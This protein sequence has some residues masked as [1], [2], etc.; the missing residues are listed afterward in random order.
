MPRKQK[1]KVYRTPIGFHDAYVAAPSQKAALEAWGSEHDLFARGVAERIDD[2]ALTREPLEKPGV[3]I[4][5]LRGTTAE[6]IAALPA[7]KHSG[8][9]GRAAQPSQVEEGQA[10]KVKPD[11]RPVSRPKPKPRPD[12]AALDRAEQALAAAKARHERELD[13]LR[14]REAELARERRQTEQAQDRERARLERALQKT[15]EAYERAMRLW[16]G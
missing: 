13:A 10:R 2:A 1:L 9:P 6:Q 7:R 4:R 16:R 8:R 11:A 15:R 12:R 14:R 5:R 3:V